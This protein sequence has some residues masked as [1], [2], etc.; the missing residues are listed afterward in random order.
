MKGGRNRLALKPTSQERH[1]TRALKFFP[2]G[3]IPPLDRQSR[4][5]YNSIVYRRA[6]MGRGRL[7]ARPEL[8]EG[9]HLSRAFS[10]LYP[11]ALTC[12]STAPCSRCAA[13]VAPPSESNLQFAICILQ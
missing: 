4:I 2:H 1:F 8:V 6:A 5:V 3:T 10:P 11:K 12:A 7:K 9:Y 13:T